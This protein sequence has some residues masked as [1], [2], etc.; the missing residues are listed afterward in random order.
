MEHDMQASLP[1]DPVSRE[2]EDLHDL[3]SRR[4]LR[5]WVVRAVWCLLV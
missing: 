2:L 4:G 3:A 5:P 1:G